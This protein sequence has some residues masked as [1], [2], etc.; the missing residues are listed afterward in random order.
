MAVRNTK[1]HHYPPP[2][3]DSMIAQAQSEQP[4]V[5]K[6]QTRETACNVRFWYY[7]DPVAKT[8][9]TVD[10][11]FVGWDD[12]DL[13]TQIKYHWKK[14]G[15]LHAAPLTQEGEPYEHESQEVSTEAPQE[16]VSK[17]G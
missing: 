2:G 8:T 10:K 1:T 5:L 9:A 13:Q 17:K 11:L 15:M 14:N 4:T 7:V 12:A 16:E 6:P 3:K